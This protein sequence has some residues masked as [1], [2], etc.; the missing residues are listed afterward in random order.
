MLMKIQISTLPSWVTGSRLSESLARVK[1]KVPP[2][3]P[4]G[5]ALGV[6]GGAAPPPPAAREGVAPAP[7]A[8]VGATA[9]TFWLIVMGAWVAVAAAGW[10]LAAGAGVAAGVPPQ[11]ARR[12]LTALAPPSAAA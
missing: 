3:A 1:V 7:R 8:W 11:A 2:T 9:V 5:G 12:A 4:A 6:T 10:V